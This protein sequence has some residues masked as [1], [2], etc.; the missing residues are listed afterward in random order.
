[1]RTLLI[2]QALIIVGG[3]YYIYTLS[4]TND[5]ANSNL[6]ENSN[7][8]IQ[9]S[10][11]DSI[12]GAEQVDTATEVEAEADASDLPIGNDIGMEFPIPDNEMDLQVR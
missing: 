3:A 2:I 9:S 1:M 11:T 8:I 12:A 5:D 10:T 6:N 7:I 4:H